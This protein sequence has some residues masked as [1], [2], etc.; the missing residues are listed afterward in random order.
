MQKR[1]LVSGLQSTCPI[2]SISYLEQGL[3][4]HFIISTHFVEMP[5]SCAHQMPLLMLMNDVC[6]VSLGN[7]A[8]PGASPSRW[9]ARHILPAAPGRHGAQ[10][11]TQPRPDPRGSSLLP[12]WSPRWPVNVGANLRRGHWLIYGASV[13]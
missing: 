6:E 8:A 13:S 1:R 7:Q 12:I 4:T 9:L 5:E 11:R 10:V 3:K 2:C